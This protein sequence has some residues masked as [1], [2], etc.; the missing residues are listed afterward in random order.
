[1]RHRMT[2][3]SLVALSLVPALAMATPPIQRRAAERGFPAKGCAHCH[4]FD[5]DHMAE[6]AR[7]LGIKPGDCHACHGTRLPKWGA[8]LFNER[9]KWLVVEKER[10]KA[11]SVDP[12]WLKDYKG[13]EKAGKK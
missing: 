10:L 6:K 8:A 2:K 13:Q 9:G 7:K 4:T 3:A 12:A 11:E 1:M 5:T